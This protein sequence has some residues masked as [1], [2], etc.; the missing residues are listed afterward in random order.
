MY[1][2]ASFQDSLAPSPVWQ[3]IPTYSDYNL[4]GVF[5]RCMAGQG[6]AQGAAGVFPHRIGQQQGKKQIAAICPDAL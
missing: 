1:A 6:A 4:S 2:T 3:Q 5:W